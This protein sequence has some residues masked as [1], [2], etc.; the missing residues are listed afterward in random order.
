M[1]APRIVDDI[2]ALDGELWNRLAADRAPPRYELVR[3]LDAGHAQ[4]HHYCVVEADGAYLCLAR[5][6]ILPETQGVLGPLLFGRAANAASRLGLQISDAVVCGWSFGYGDSLLIEPR[7]KNAERVQLLNTVCDTIESLA[8]GRMVVITGL[9][10]KDALLAAVLERRGYCAASGLPVGRLDIEW[11]DLAG[12]LAVLRRK[13]KNSQ[14]SARWEINRYR[15]SGAVV[16]R[17]RGGAIEWERICRLLNDHHRRLNG[18]SPGHE[19]SGLR[20]LQA[21]LGDDLCVYVSRQDSEITAA[22]IGVRHGHELNQVWIG[23]DHEAA[24]RNFTYFNLVFYA[25]AADFANLG[26]RRVWVGTAAYDAKIR[27]GCRVLPTRIFL[28]PPTRLAAGIYRPAFALQ[29]AWYA[30]KFRRFL[31]PA[32]A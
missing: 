8:A 29:R 30:L 14:Q 24:G 7:L 17:L 11:P 12:Y 32:G 2:G 27:R 20:R 1:S 28:R 15:R 4:R 22:C 9:F 26:I 3:A 31:D 21:A 5:L 13:N 23:I 6:T 10:A 19:P 25:P 16:E 18:S